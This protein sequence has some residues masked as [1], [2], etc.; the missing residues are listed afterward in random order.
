MNP[1][2]QAKIS[3]I[4]SGVSG[5]I[6]YLTTLPPEQQDAVTGPIVALIPVHWR[7]E[8][9]LIGKAIMTVSTFW[10]IFKAAHSGPQTP[11]V[12]VVPPAPKPP[13]AAEVQ[14]L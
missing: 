13:V 1:K 5:F 2:L 12:D 10:A 7:P 11:P 8:I 3:A 14:K 4:V 9:S 6:V